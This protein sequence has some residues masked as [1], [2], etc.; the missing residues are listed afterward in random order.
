MV[1]S[2][3]ERK[4]KRREANRKNYE[5]YKEKYREKNK[6][7]YETNKEYCR[8][9]QKIYSETEKGKKI[10]RINIWKYRGVVCDN[11]DALYDY[12]INCKECE[13]CGIEFTESKIRT[14]ETRCLDHDHKTKK[15]RNVLCHSCNVKRG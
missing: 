6:K 9:Q 3:E 13:S 8:E 1:M 7:F 14:S 10:N 15:F 4:E 5:K 11:Y 12:F 2:E